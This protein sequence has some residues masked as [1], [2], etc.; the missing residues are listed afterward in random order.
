[1]SYFITTTEK[2]IVEELVKLFK[3]N[4][5]KLHM[6]SE[7]MTLDKGLQFAVRLMKKLNKILE[8]ETKLLIVFH[9]QTDKQME[10]MN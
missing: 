7:S 2:V 9:L 10:K 3:N 5:Q 4:V 1:M 8:I 6:L